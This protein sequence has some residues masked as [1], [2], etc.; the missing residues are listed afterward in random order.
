MTFLSNIIEGKVSFLCYFV[1]FDNLKF[2]FLSPFAW[3]Y[4]SRWC[5]K[6]GG[7][8]CSECPNQDSLAR[9]IPTREL[10]VTRVSLYI[11]RKLSPQGL[12]I[13]MG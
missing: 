3:H 13:S 7:A 4:V 1:D 12:K 2:N 9:L 8:S 11:C 6:M 10:F 5:S